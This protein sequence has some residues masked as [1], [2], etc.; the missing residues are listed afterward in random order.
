MVSIKDIQRYCDTI[1]AEFKP[2]R[3]I[4]F[5]SHAYGTP[6]AD[7]DVDVFVVMPKSKRM[8]R[9]ASLTIREKVSADFP[10]DIIDPAFVAA[11]LSEGD[12]F[13]EEITAKGRVMYEGGNA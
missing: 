9:R 8:G 2:E 10:V 5:G 13:L 6:S 4:L 3:I 1:G 11:R 12:T 7:S